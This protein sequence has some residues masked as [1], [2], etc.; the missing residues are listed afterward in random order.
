MYFDEPVSTE[1]GDVR[2][3]DKLTIYFQ[4]QNV[5]GGEE[6][7]GVE[8]TDR[9]KHGNVTAAVVTFVDARGK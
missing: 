2:I 1:P 5:S 7:C 8:V 3:R 6:V 9:D 4:K